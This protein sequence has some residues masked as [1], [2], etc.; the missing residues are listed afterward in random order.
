M[1]TDSVC[2]HVRACVA[3]QCDSDSVCVHVR[4][5]VAYQCDS[6][7]VS[8][9][10]WLVL[11]L[12]NHG[13]CRLGLVGLLWSQGEVSVKNVSDVNRTSHPF[14][15]HSQHSHAKLH[16]HSAIPWLFTGKLNMR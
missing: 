6:D 13:S 3:Y 14:P 4:A 12:N 1:P 5:C 9:G 2:V 7:S 16:M 8:L 15:S 11:T 10:T